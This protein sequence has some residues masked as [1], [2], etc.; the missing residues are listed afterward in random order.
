[1]KNWEVSLGKWMAFQVEWLTL[2]KQKMGVLWAPNLKPNV[3]KEVGHGDNCQCLEPLVPPFSN[4]LLSVRQEGAMISRSVRS[5]VAFVMPFFILGSTEWCLHSVR[6]LFTLHRSVFCV[7]TCSLLPRKA[8]ATVVW[9]TGR[10]LLHA[11]CQ[12]VGSNHTHTVA[13]WLTGEL[14]TIHIHEHGCGWSIGSLFK[15]CFQR[16]RR[17]SDRHINN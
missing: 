10:L 14:H 1:M 13:G 5:G 9:P 2:K 4:Y 8:L 16:Q 6:S 3:Q 17:L 12:L 7:C 15:L 11:T